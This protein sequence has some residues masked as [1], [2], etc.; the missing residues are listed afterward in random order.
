M[1]FFGSGRIEIECPAVW[2][3]TPGV[4]DS[5]TVCG[6]GAMP[7]PSAGCGTFGST[8]GTPIC[9]ARERKV[10]AVG[11]PVHAIADFRHDIRKRLFN[12]AANQLPALGWRSLF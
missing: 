5:H 9:G 12:I 3:L 11:P 8:P 6:L 1:F 2:S 4:P 7:P 10:R